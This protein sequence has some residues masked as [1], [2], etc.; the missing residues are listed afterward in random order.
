MSFHGQSPKV[1]RVRFTPQA[2]DPV[3]PQEGDFFYADGSSRTEGLY[4]YAN[5]SWAVVSS[6]AANTFDSLVLTPQSSDPGSPSEGMLFVS[7]GT[8]RAEGLWQYKNA[9][10]VQITG[11]VNYQ[12]FVRKEPVE[13][14][15]AT[16]TAIT[17]ASGLE[18]GDTIDGVTLVTGDL[19]LV[20][21]Q[22]TASENGVYVVPASGAPSRHSS[23]DTFGELN[24]YVAYVA[25]G[26]TN[27]NT[28]YFQTATLT[29]LS[30]NQTWSTT[31][32]TETFTVPEDVYELQIEACAGGGGGSGS[33]ADSDNGHT[34]GGAGGAGALP[35]F[36]TKKVTPG[37][38]ITVNV[39]PG[40]LP[41]RSIYTSAAGDANAGGA[42]GNTVLTFTD[43][44]LTFYGA[45]G[46][47]AGTNGTN[48]PTGG[49]GGA[50]LS[51]TVVGNP[52]VAAGGNGGY[53]TSAGAEG[54]GTSGETTQW[55]AG[56][57]A[58]AVVSG[59]A[60]GGGGGAGRGAGAAGASASNT[61]AACAAASSG[62]GGGGGSRTSTTTG[63][64]RSGWGG[65][66]YVRFSW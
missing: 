9:E 34:C 65:S 60:V 56:G 63:T 1:T 14:R 58:G 23:A 35:L 57:A 46:G 19:V 30:D 66:G 61:D 17:L 21:N 12:E 52:G 13:V 22:V 54:A 36:F 6:A 29:S 15:V 3:N 39:G 24:G 28:F 50:A 7:D 59:A 11:I 44:T 55:A 20:K 40:G 64:Y 10:W 33:R 16:T 51:T 4:V 41:A 18:N 48:P 26:T 31:P 47:A 25:R 2:T 42:G 32:P 49:T 43:Q 27:T 8:P 5:G 45:N 62:A 37:D 38:I 53:Q